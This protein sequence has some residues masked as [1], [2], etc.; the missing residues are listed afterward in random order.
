MDRRVTEAGG[1]RALHCKHATVAVTT[2]SPQQYQLLL[3]LRSVCAAK[4]M[5]PHFCRLVGTQVQRLVVSPRG[6]AT[7][8]Y[9]G[10][11]TKKIL[12]PHTI[13]VQD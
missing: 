12:Q 10:G 5:E 9:M 13:E 11:C 3:V 2:H 6:S 8:V 1:R 4:P 7:A